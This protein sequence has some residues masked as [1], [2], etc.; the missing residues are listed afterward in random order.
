MG[1]FLC[2]LLI[3]TFP[4][5]AVVDLLRAMEPLAN[6]ARESEFRLRLHGLWTDQQM[7][8]LDHDRPACSIAELHADPQAKTRNPDVI[9][10]G[11]EYELALECRTAPTVAGDSTPSVW[12]ITA[13]PL[14]GF[15]GLP[16]L[17]MSAA[18]KVSPLTADGAGC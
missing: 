12:S 13:T 1:V 9:L 7:Y 16:R 3:G 2:G 17:C 10:K 8:L 15:E 14:P 5:L 6:R 18:G 11:F 4:V